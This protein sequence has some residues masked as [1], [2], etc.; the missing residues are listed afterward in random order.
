MTNHTDVLIFHTQICV[1]AS[2][3]CLKADA[4]LI[5]ASPRRI[6]APK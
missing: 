5:F 3:I 2:Q 6:N 1:G 4:N